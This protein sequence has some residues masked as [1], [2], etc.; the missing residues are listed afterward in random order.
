MGDF[1]VTLVMEGEN[2]MSVEESLEKAILSGNNLSAAKIIVDV[3]YAD[4]VEYGTGPSTESEE[5]KSE[6]REM[7]S[8][9]S[10]LDWVMG[11]A[12]R[13]AD[14][15]KNNG[16]YMADGKT[17]SESKCRRFAYNIIMKH[18]RVGMPA[19]PYFRPAIYSVLDNLPDDYFDKGNSVIDLLEEMADTMK[20]ILVEHDTIYSMD[21]YDHIFVQLVTDRSEVREAASF[22]QR[23]VRGLSDVKTDESNLTRMD[24]TLY[25][26]SIRETNRQSK[27]KFQ[28]LTPGPRTR[29]SPKPMS[30]YAKNKKYW[31]RSKPKQKRTRR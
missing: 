1:D 23:P 5:D 3:P 2:G 13:S 8:K 29:A 30:N 28:N 12:A 22:P 14:F 15:A 20:R 21:L 19:Q 9:Y 27:A 31:G 7:S 26:S 10:V 16:L 25:R 18:K 17:I 24:H 11:R 4:Y 6:A